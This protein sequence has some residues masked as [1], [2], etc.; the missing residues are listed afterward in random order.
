ML[1]TLIVNSLFDPY[2]PLLAERLVIGQVR[3]MFHTHCSPN[4]LPP[5]P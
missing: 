5:P 2:N 1:D 3:F 4:P